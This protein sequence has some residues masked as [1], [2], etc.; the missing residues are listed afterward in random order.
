[1]LG[2]GT[3]LSVK[4]A[5][6]MPDVDNTTEQMVYRTRYT[7]FKTRRLQLP[8]CLAT[9]LGHTDPTSELD[10][11][12]AQSRPFLG[13]EAVFGLFP[14]GRAERLYDLFIAAPVAQ[15]TVQAVFLI[16]IQTIADAAV[17]G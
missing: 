9:D 8:R 12:L 7:K 6:L 17:S 13:F 1:M 11:G 14:K 5:R 10:G 2:I 16:G 4:N 3:E 15:H